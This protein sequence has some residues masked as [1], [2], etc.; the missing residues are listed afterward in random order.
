[1]RSGGMSAP[2]GRSGRLRRSRSVAGASGARGSQ[3]S[4]TRALADLA[5]DVDR[6][7][8]LAREAVDHRQAEAGALADVLGGEEGLGHLLQ[9]LGRDAAAVVLDGEHDI[10][11]GRQAERIVRRGRG[12]ARR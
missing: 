7:A 12:V 2:P 9:Y 10:V 8:R 11:A 5:V 1:M 6:A 4:T 3:I